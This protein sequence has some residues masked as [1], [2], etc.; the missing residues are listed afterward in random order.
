MKKRNGFTL[1]EVVLAVI[2]VGMVGVAVASLSVV[3][4]RDSTATNSHILLRNTLSSA[5]RQIRK[6][7]QT[8]SVLKDT[9]VIN[10]AKKVVPDCSVV[11]PYY[12]ILQLQPM[13]T[14]DYI[15]YFLQA[16][17]EKAYPMRLF[18]SPWMTPE[19]GDICK[20]VAQKGCT[21]ENPSLAGGRIIRRV[22]S[23]KEHYTPRCEDCNLSTWSCENPGQIDV[24]FQKR[25][26]VLLENVKFI[27]YLAELQYQVPLFKKMGGNALKV[28]L[29]VEIP[30]SA[31]IVNEATEEV[32]FTQ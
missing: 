26:S 18:N 21:C 24:C 14:T 32:F 3:V 9:P 27:P 20:P 12:R 13:G 28:N 15:I 30:D 7:V 17:K 11:S 2:I 16:G 19:D 5:L 22:V 10:Q 6:D 29:I 1:T 31:P 23:R 25:D 8:S 4:S